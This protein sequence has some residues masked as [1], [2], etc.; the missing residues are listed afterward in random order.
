MLIFRSLSFRRLD[1]ERAALAQAA[2]VSTSLAQTQA[3]LATEKTTHARTR[4]A[5]QGL[6]A[7]VEGLQDQLT[8]MQRCGHCG[9]DFPFYLF[10]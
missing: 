1:V 5:M 4:D 8:D 2:A 10:V 7:V 9:G 3:E 6:A